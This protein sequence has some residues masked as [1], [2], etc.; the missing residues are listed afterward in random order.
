MAI[1]T[2]VF[3]M[4]R[5]RFIHVPAGGR[6][7]LREL[8]SRRGF[9]VMLK[10]LPLYLFVAMF[11]ALFDQTGSTWIFQSQDMDRRSSSAS[12]GCPRRS[13]R[14]TRCSC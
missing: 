5:K 13:S 9:K 14:S 3:W 10:L 4:G 8:F 6:A 1:A 11:W 12:S 2:L 7:F